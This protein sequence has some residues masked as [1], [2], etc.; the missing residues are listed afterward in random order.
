MNPD[1]EMLVE[2]FQASS[3]ME[4]LVIQ[5]LLESSGIPAA[6]KSRQIPMFDGVAK[7][8]NP[9]WGHVVVLTENE[10]KARDLIVGYLDALEGD[11]NLPTEDEVEE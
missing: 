10:R 4:A 5:S 2:V 11:D 8:Y 3:E 6:L 1:E 9:V 7:V